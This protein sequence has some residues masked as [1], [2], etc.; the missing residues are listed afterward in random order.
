MIM[1]AVGISET[2]VCSETARRYI[3]EGFH[4]HTH[5]RENLK[6]HPHHEGVVGDNGFVETFSEIRKWS[7]LMF[8]R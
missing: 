3:P 5:R 4:L 2:S 6:S 8:V 1:E 7:T